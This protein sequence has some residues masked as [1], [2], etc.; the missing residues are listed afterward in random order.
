MKLPPRHLLTPLP[1]GWG[2]KPEE[3][4]QENLRVETNSNKW[5]KEK[6]KKQATDKKKRENPKQVMQR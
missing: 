3:Q 5:R 4:K 1:V 2:T 6:K